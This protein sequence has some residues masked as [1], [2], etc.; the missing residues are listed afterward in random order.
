MKS[1]YLCTLAILLSVG[2]SGC[3]EPRKTPPNVGV[4]FVNAAPTQGQI[5]FRREQA[6]EASLNYTESSRRSFNVD[7]YTFRFETTPAGEETTELLS[8]IQEMVAGTEYHIIATEVGGQIQQVV[9]EFPASTSDASD[10]QLSAQH[11]APM[12]N[13]VDIFIVPPGTDPLTA[14]PLGSLS[15]G[16]N[17]APLSIAPGT[18]EF[19][20]TEAANPGTVLL[21]STSFPIEAG[22]SALFTILDGG[23][24]G[25]APITV[26]VSGNAA[27]SFVDQNLQASIRVINGISDQSSLD[28][29]IDG[30]LTPPLIPGLPFGVVSD[31]E[32]IEPGVR[33][34]TASPAGN[35]SVIVVDS[36]FGADAGRF[37]TALIANAPG[38]ASTNHS[39]DD[40][41]AIAGEA[42]L[43]LY[44]A[45]ALFP[46]VDIYITPPGTDLNT[47]PPTAGVAAGG[48]V[49]NTVLA[50][51]IHELTI[52]SAGTQTVLS[53]P[54]ALTLDDSGFYGIIMTDGVGGA[55]IDLLFIDDFN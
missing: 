43:S 18:Y 7:T 8:F 22:I 42:K 6:L 52:R 36:P 46:F 32:S 44:H 35:P 49:P 33:N 10:A 29:G 13:A 20:L 38:A 15:L 19:V 34:L 30:N 3:D 1:A 28:I 24:T 14:V 48:I 26:A 31:Y 45:A 2:L 47:I 39:L 41:R 9:L 50:A 4:S 25:F 16:E 55:T 40:Y 51:G 12:L 5:N 23:G 37:G 11:L 17:F 53:G 21:R 27:F 54:T